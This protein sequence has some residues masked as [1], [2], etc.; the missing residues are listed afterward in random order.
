MKLDVEKKR[1]LRGGIALSVLLF[2]GAWMTAGCGADGATEEHISQD[3]GALTSGLPTI[4]AVNRFRSALTPIAPGGSGAFTASAVHPHD[5]SFMIVGT[6]LNGVFRSIDDGASFQN[7]S[8]DIDAR[9][10]FSVAIVRRPDNTD[11]AYVGT[12]DGV[13]RSTHAAGAAGLLGDHWTLQT[14][15]FESACITAAPNTCDTRRPHPVQVVRVDPDDPQIVWAGI[16]GATLG[17][18]LSHGDVKN[19]P[20]DIWRVYKSTNG[21]NSWRGVLTFDPNDAASETVGPAVFDIAIDANN[22]RRVAVASDAGLF[23]TQNGGSKWF[24][25]GKPKVEVGVLVDYASG[26]FSWTSC[27][28]NVKCPTKFRTSSLCVPVVKGVELL[29]QPTVTG[30]LPV[31]PEVNEI[32]PNVRSAKFVDGELFAL[33]W[34]SGYAGRIKTS[35]AETAPAGYTCNSATDS[36]GRDEWTDCLGTCSNSGRADPKLA[37]FRGG[38]WHSR[39]LNDWNYIKADAG[40]VRLR[41]DGNS[42]LDLKYTTQHAFF[43]VD[44]TG[45]GRMVLAANFP[46][47]EHAGFSI[48]EPVSWTAP[49]PNFPPQ[50]WVSQ[51]GACAPNTSCMEAT[52]MTG[53]WSKPQQTFPAGAYGLSVTEWAPDSVSFLYGHIMG[54]WRVA[55][56]SSTT[57]QTLQPSYSIEHLTQEQLAVNPSYWRSTGADVLCPFAGVAH[58]DK[59]TMLVG[60]VDVGVLKAKISKGHTYWEKLTEHSTDLVNHSLTGGTLEV[61]A[62]GQM[63]AM[64]NTYV[65]VVDKNAADPKKSVVYANNDNNLGDVGATTG[66][67][68]NSMMMAVYPA[69]RKDWQIIGGL[70]YDKWCTQKSAQPHCDGNGL[71]RDLTIRS[72]AMDPFTDANRRAGRRRLMAGTRRGGIW[73]Y[74][75]LLS[76]GSQWTQLSDNGAANSSCGLLAGS[77]SPNTGSAEVSE[78]VSLKPQGY[79]DHFLATVWNQENSRY[80]NR[81]G[82][83]S[84]TSSATDRRHG[85]AGVYLIHRQD[86]AGT[87]TYF[88]KRLMNTSATYHHCQAQSSCQYG[89]GVGT[90]DG[91][92]KTVPFTNAVCECNPLAPQGG[93][94]AVRRSDSSLRIV[95]AGNLNSRPVIFAANIA[96]LSTV[97]G[98]SVDWKAVVSFNISSSSGFRSTWG[99]QLWH[100]YLATLS[101]Q[102]RKGWGNDFT[103][104]YKDTNRSFQSIR[105]VPSMPSVLLATMNDQPVAFRN[106]DHRVYR[107]NDAGYTWQVATELE[108]LPYKSVQRIDFSP[109]NE[110]I[111]I[112]GTCTSLYTGTSPYADLDGD[113]LIEMVDPQPKVPNNWVWVSP[114]ATT[115]SPILEGKPLRYLE[116]SSDKGFVS[117]FGALDSDPSRATVM[118]PDGKTVGALVVLN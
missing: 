35:S 70:Y 41:C 79:P 108:S 85:Y 48:Y 68:V 6:E 4:Q 116:G 103:D 10:I 111:Y 53:M 12:T 25:I 39:D 112:S 72:L 83:V 106:A 30:C 86:A 47:G 92:N 90:R 118:S 28:N 87:P 57:Y 98:N 54:L 40:H 80:G 66:S 82:W 14:N 84:A 117:V 93:L 21:G 75:P 107:S 16:G 59:K 77:R 96:D 81:G 11:V 91:S 104:D 65:M 60:S 3:N 22:P 33:I 5:P 7:I 13:Y 19:R 23:Y 56:R 52:T 115:P 36:A 45:S 43:D 78:I 37:F 20:D 113:G 94:E 15:G 26:Q 9:L 1:G 76:A 62:D 44:P 101:V 34:D 89:G 58:L 8:A 38:V 97:A 105:S 55:P 2:T 109:S 61:T 31:R 64:D 73:V 95:V 42:K 88:C 27:V 99:A 50:H 100:E 17:N 110:H 114:K 24:A 51:A 29:A 18:N 74:D 32:Q 102:E 67:D 69:N 49:I 63:I 46:R 71:S